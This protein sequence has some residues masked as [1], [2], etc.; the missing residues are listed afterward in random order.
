MILIKTMEQNTNETITITI[1]IE[2]YKFLKESALWLTCLENAG[3]DNWEGWDYA[4]DLL[5]GYGND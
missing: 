5:D 3:V 4:C 1:P 2:E